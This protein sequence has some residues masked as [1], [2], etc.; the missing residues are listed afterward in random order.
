MR[1]H[2]LA[3]TSVRKLSEGKFRRELRSGRVL[4]STANP[5]SIAL[6][7]H[8]LSRLISPETTR[9]QDGREKRAARIP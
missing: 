2:I 6:N 5:R 7:L 8:D 9:S 1:P 3:S 4:R